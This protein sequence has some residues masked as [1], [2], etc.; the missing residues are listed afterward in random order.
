MDNVMSIFSKNS[1]KLKYLYGIISI[2][3]ICLFSSLILVKSIHTYPQLGDEDVHLKY[4]AKI[5]KLKIIE[6]KSFREIGEEL[7]ISKEM[8]MDTPV[9]MEYILGAVMYLKYKKEFLALAEKPFWD[10]QASY[11]E[12]Q[13]M[14]A[15]IPREL[16]NFSRYSSMI[17]STLSCI[18]LWLILCHLKIYAGAL[19]ASLLLFCSDL[20]KVYSFISCPEIY[21]VLFSACAVLF[22]LKF[23]SRF[24]HNRKSFFYFLVLSAVFIS[25]ALLIKLTAIIFIMYFLFF[26][27]LLVVFKKSIGLT[28]KIKLLLIMVVIFPLVISIMSYLFHPLFHIYP[29]TGWIKIVMS[30]L[31]YIGAQKLAFCE[32]GLFFIDKFVIIPHRI[33][34]WAVSI[35]NSDGATYLFF[36][37]IIILFAVNMVKCF[38]C[39]NKVRTKKSLVVSISA[40]CVFVIF[41]L[42]LFFYYDWE[43]PHKATL[44]DPCVSHTVLFV[45]P[46]RGWVNQKQK[47][48]N[49]GKNKTFNLCDSSADEFRNLD[50]TLSRRRSWVQTGTVLKMNYL[51]LIGINIMFLLGMRDALRRS[52]FIKKNKEC[53]NSMILGSLFLWICL[54][55]IIFQHCDWERYYLIGVYFYYIIVGI[56]I[57]TIEKRIYKKLVV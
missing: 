56:G 4:S 11:K 39:N 47:V 34:Y 48:S 38:K 30:E 6:N 3:I 26:L 15:E 19:I 52:N 46:L 54:L 2:F 5:V 24:C 23:Y 10:Y 28:V 50:F 36:F 49:C 22:F 40:F 32:G 13:E 14:G 21:L 20:F 25:L 51:L 29:L 9:I 35:I 57:G 53:K 16:L 41:Y 33:M 31:S 7:F 18:V 1:D 44:I 43:R 17:T 12:N 45:R 27:I 55:Q 8:E 42:F 37:G